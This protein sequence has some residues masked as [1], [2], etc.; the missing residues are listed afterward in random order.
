MFL[1]KR[2]GFVHFGNANVKCYFFVFFF[3]YIKKISYYNT[4]IT[5]TVI[6]ANIITIL[7]I[8]LS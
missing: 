1:K 8:Y 7:I 6:P 3:N 4:T 2:T 5:N